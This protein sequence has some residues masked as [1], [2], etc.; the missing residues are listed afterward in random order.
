MP[1]PND[2]DEVLDAFREGRQAIDDFGLRRTLVF[3]RSRVWYSGTGGAWAPSGARGRGFPVDVEVQALPTP[4]VRPMSVQ[5]VMASAGRYREGDIVV[6][7]VTPKA[8]PTTGMEL[9][10]FTRPVTDASTERHVVLVER[11]GTPWHVREGTAR[12]LTS[13]PYDV[14]TAV[15]CAN[16]LRAAYAAHWSDAYAHTAAD[17]APAPGVAATDLATAVTLAGALRAAWVAH[18]ANVA[19]HPEADAYPVTAPAPGVGDAQ[20]LLVLLHDLLRV[21][22]AHVA[23]GQVSECEVIEARADRAFSHTVMVRPTR[24]VP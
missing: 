6:D 2:R 16:A 4:R 8:E 17:L 7:K 5:Y 21:F 9:H 13:G 3:T 22:N 15:T 23:P 1:A 12:L 24:R 19:L 18:R 20:A 10:L 14:P 11:G